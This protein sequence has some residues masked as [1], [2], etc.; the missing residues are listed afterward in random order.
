MIWNEQ[1]IRDE[2]IALDAITNL[3]GAEVPILLGNGESTIGSF[4]P[5]GNMCFTFSRGYFQ[6]PDWPHESA[7]NIIRHEYAHYMDFVI[8]GNSGHGKTWKSCCVRIGAM[9]VRLYREDRNLFYID[10]HRKEA[11]ASQ[12]YDLYNVGNIIRHPKFGNGTISSIS[13]EGLER[14]VDVSFST[15]GSKRLTLKWINENC[16]VSV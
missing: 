9:P 10:R 16:S 14:L 12:I 2:M 3:S 4:S 11:E 1:T 7:V 5:I 15:V 8:Y 6:N 13:G